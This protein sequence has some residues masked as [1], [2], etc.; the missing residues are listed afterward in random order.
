M[1]LWITVCHFESRKDI[2]VVTDDLTDGKMIRKS[3]W[4]TWRDPVGHPW[5]CNCYLTVLNEYNV[6]RSLVLHGG[7]GGGGGIS[8]VYFKKLIYHY[9]ACYRQFKLD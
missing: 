3:L 6:F 9:F 4:A 8:C 7:G 1:S 5:M 2:T